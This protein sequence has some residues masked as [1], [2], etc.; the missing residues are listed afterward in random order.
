MRLS[1]DRSFL[2]DDVA[3]AFQ[4]ESDFGMSVRIQ[5]VLFL[6][7]RVRPMIAKPKGPGIEQYFSIGQVGVRW[8]EFDLASDIRKVSPDTL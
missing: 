3:Q 1:E 4:F 6:G 5:P 2:P 7:I 8:E